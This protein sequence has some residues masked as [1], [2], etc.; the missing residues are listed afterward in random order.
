MTRPSRSAVE[1]EAPENLRMPRSQFDKPYNNDDYQ[2]MEYWMPNPFSLTWPDINLRFLPRGQS[3]VDWDDWVD[4][5]MSCFIICKSPGLN[6]PCTDPVKCYWGIYGYEGNWL[7]FYQKAIN[8]V[9]RVNKHFHSEWRLYPTQPDPLRV[10]P[11]RDAGVAF[12]DAEWEANP[13]GPGDNVSVEFWDK[14]TGKLLC[15][16]LVVN[17]SCRG[18]ECCG[19]DDYVA[20]SW[21]ED[22]TPETCSAGGSIDLYVLD[23]CGP[24][25]WAVSGAGATLDSAETTGRVNGLN[26]DSGT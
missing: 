9:I 8:M 7:E 4:P 13:P 24:F 17:L 3:G 16:A 11:P 26:V 15:Q 5:G 20:V 10:Y 22:S 6:N 14:E 2:A 1:A 25:T 23:G 21:D 19:A 18:E 12:G